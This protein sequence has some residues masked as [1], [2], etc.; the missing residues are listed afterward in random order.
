MGQQFVQVVCF[1]HR[2]T[3]LKV[4]LTEGGRGLGFIDDDDG[5]VS[6][7]SHTLYVDR[8]EECIKEIQEEA[9]SE[10]VFLAFNTRE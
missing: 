9:A 4:G 7:Y 1:H 5:S 2:D 6:G 8:C 10:Q 3:A